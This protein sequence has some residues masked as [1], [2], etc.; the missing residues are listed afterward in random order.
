MTKTKKTNQDPLKAEAS[1]E[2]LMEELS[3]VLKLMEDSSTSLENQLVNY[4]KG[5]KLCQELELRLK[6]AEEKILIINQDGV[7]EDFD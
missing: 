6:K 5:M 1:Y 2:E 7:E 3:T 4:E